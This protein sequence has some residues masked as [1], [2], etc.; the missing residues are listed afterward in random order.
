[1]IVFC[2]FCGSEDEIDLGDLM[3]VC[4]DCHEPMEPKPDDPTE[5]ELNAS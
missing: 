3:P 2:P 1:M 4:E 5:D